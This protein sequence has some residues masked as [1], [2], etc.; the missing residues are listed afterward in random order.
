MTDFANSDFVVLGVNADD[1]VSTARASAT[2]QGLSWRHFFDG[3]RGP[4]TQTWN[5]SSWPS[6]IL[7]DQSGVIRAKNFDYKP[8]EEIVELIDGLLSESNASS[9]H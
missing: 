9:A 8:Y 1:N 4:I 7:I 3:K 5:I 6:T 2:K